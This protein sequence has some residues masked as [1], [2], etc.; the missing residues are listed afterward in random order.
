M[1]KIPEQTVDRLG[2]FFNQRQ[3]PGR[4]GL[5]VMSVTMNDSLVYRDDIER[6]LESALR[7]NQH[8][9]VKEGDIAYNM[10]RMWQGACG[11][12]LHDGIVS[13][14]YV[15]LEP[16]SCI[17]SRFAYHWFKS[18]R[19]IHHFWAY[20]H[21][22]TEDR[23]RLY[24]DNFCEIP[25]SPPRIEQ[26]RQIANLLDQ[27]DLAIGR[28]EELIAAKR[29]KR[30]QLMRTILRQITSTP[31]LASV[32]DVV[33]GQS[34]SSA[35]YNDAGRG[36]PLI[37]GPGDFDEWGVSPSVWTTQSPKKA[38]RGAIIMSV[39]APVGLLTRSDRDVCLGRGVCALVANEK[40]TDYIFGALLALS[41]KWTRLSQGTSFDAIGTDQFDEFD[42]P[43]PENQERVLIGALHASMFQEEH[44][45]SMTLDRMRAQKRGLS[46]KLFHEEWKVFKHIKTSQLPPEAGDQA[47]TSNGHRRSTKLAIK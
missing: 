45:L 19:M 6:R 33:M 10:M 20:S 4:A 23:L 14:A 39:R 2:D 41:G 9:L 34:P 44:Q 1:S 24:F 38:A 16:K 11:L 18:A 36:I 47:A 32:V 43:W 25:A 17:D 27:W 22:L 46:Q 8:L 26:Q 15:V 29:K 13:P 21:G 12:A 7:P 28:I 5:P 42:F 40:D 3:E 37:Q 35:A 31:P 30:M